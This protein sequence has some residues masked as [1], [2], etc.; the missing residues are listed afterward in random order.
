MGKQ[1]PFKPTSK[2]RVGSIPTAPTKFKMAKLTK[3]QKKEKK[4]KAP[5]GFTCNYCGKTDSSVRYVADP[6][7]SE[8]YERESMY[9][10][11]SECYSDR[12]D[13]I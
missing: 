3:K 4:A 6:F 9:F 7:V 8:I 10:L 5:V 1:R 12:L 11:C 13:D 2:D